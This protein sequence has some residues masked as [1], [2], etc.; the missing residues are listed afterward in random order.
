M[1][2]LNRDKTHFMQTSAEGTH[3]VKFG[4]VNEVLALI[5][6]ILDGEN[7]DIKKDNKTCNALVAINSDDSDKSTN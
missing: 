1:K 4:K 2:I 6:T 3:Q 7:G 5:D